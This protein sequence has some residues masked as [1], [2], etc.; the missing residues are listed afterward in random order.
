[1]NGTRFVIMAALTGMILP[2]SYATEPPAIPEATQVEIRKRVDNLYSTAI[3]AGVLDANGSSYFSYGTMDLDRGGAVNE[4]TLFQIAGLTRTFTATLLADMAERG[5]VNMTNL[6]KNYLPA[7]YSAPVYGS[8]KT[9]INLLHL[10]TH[11]SGLPSIPDNVSWAPAN[12]FAGYTLENMYQFLSG[13]SLTRLPGSAYESSHFGTA[14]LGQLLA[15]S[16]QMDFETLLRQR[17]LDVLGLSDTG[18]I[19]SP[20]QQSR[21]ATPYCGVVQPP[22]GEVGALAPALGLS[23]TARDLMKYLAANLGL[24]ET[25]L[26]SALTNAY[27]PRYPT[28]DGTRIGLAWVTRTKGGVSAVE[29]S[30]KANSATAA[31]VGFIPA[32]QRAVVVLATG[33]DTAEDLGRNLLNPAL[34]SLTTYPAAI[35]VPTRTLRKYVGTYEGPAWGAVQSWRITF[36][37]GRLVYTYDGD[38]GYSF[39]LYP[40]RTNVFKSNPTVIRGTAT[41]RFNSQGQVNSMLWSQL[42]DPENI[43]ISETFPKIAQ[44]SMPPELCLT[45]GATGL[46]MEL[47][48]DA[49]GVYVIEGSPDWRTWKPISTNVAGSA[50][51]PVA[52]AESMRFYRARE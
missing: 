28:P 19:L 13:F 51:I 22:I 37:R 8:S 24:I 31:Y 47:I 32:Q 46:E 17:V 44:G 20:D 18:F 49:N 5:E 7:G 1:M 23:S 21:F 40:V 27:C 45:R 35:S 38:G 11:R 4:D 16:K 6:I 14:L 48:G 2:L 41:F 9:G 29:I 12:P 39:T 25:P 15:G 52:Q 42:L 34:G 33:L 43:T 36:E 3:V 30:G 50:S 26:Y 10:A